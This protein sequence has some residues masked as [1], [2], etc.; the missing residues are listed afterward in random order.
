[1][2]CYIDS[3]EIML[4]SRVKNEGLYRYIIK[5]AKKKGIL[6]VKL[7]PLLFRGLQ[8]GS[9]VKCKVNVGTGLK[10]HIVLVLVEV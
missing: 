1:M 5:R 10:F 8:I 6:I 9:G 2:V 7:F 4:R 3:G